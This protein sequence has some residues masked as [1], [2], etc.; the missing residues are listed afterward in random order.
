M[1]HLL[2]IELLASLAGAVAETAGADK[3]SLG[4][5]RFLTAAI[6]AGSLTNERLVALKQKYESEVDSDVP[7]TIEDLTDI[8]NMISQNTTE[9]QKSGG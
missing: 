6:K 7:V 8:E 4:Y 9:I 2:L 3:R 1:D 5:L